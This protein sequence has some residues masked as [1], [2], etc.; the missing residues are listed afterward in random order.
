MNGIAGIESYTG[1]F[2]SPATMLCLHGIVY[3]SWDRSLTCAKFSPTD[4]EGSG[5][6]DEDDEFSFRGGSVSEAPFSGGEF[7]DA[8]FGI[9]IR[10][11]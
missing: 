3:M 2:T 11:L 1:T 7:G 6:D 8:M 5:D 4:A 9:D 10:K